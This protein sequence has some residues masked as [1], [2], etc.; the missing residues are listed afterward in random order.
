M[1]YISFK[2]VFHPKKNWLVTFRMTTSGFSLMEMVIA[3]VIVG[4]IA[5][6]MIPTFLV[7][8]SNDT[9]N[10]K[11]KTVMQQIQV[12]VIRYKQANPNATI[13]SSD[14]V[15]R[16]SKFISKD[17]PGAPTAA[18]NLI[19]I[20]GAQCS[21]TT[22]CYIFSDN[23]VIQ[24]SVNIS[25]DGY[26]Y[27]NVDPDGAGP[28]GGMTMLYNYDKNRITT[29]PN[30]TVGLLNNVTLAEPLGFNVATVNPDYFK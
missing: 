8:V 7:T 20:T 2:K 21:A 6:F 22:P 13:A 3:L 16:N 12:D 30:A 4:V 9:L 17:F 11:I 1:Q 5:V 29:Y 28:V 10:N 23:T 19:T 15:E 14:L 26:L 24:T 25:G 18:D 27:F